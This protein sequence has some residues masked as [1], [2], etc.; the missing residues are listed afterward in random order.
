M[1]GL[2]GLVL[3]NFL[4]LLLGAI[5]RYLGFG[6]ERARDL[7]PQ[8]R[9]L[10]IPLVILWLAAPFIWFISLYLLVLA[11]FK[12]QVG[13]DVPE[14]IVLCICIGLLLQHG[15]IAFA[16]GWLAGSEAVTPYRP[17]N[18]F[19][20]DVPLVPLFQPEQADDDIWLVFPVEKD[21]AAGSR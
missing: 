1:E 4:G 3:A 19:Q 8:S 6:R 2:S 12:Y 5:S 10:I 16:I 13:F 14:E 18:P 21:E 15:C 9:L 7:P 20:E 11:S 17:R